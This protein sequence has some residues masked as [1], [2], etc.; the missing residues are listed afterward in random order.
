MTE[1]EAESLQRSPQSPRG[2][3][4]PAADWPGNRAVLPVDLEREGAA[5]GARQRGHG[6]RARAARRLRGS[7]GCGGERDPNAQPL[8]RPARPPPASSVSRAEETSAFPPWPRSS[9]GEGSAPPPAA[10]PGLARTGRSA[11]A[12]TPG[13]TALRMLRVA[14]R[15]DALPAADPGPT[16]TAVAER[17]ARALAG[18]AGGPSRRASGAASAG[19]RSS[20]PGLEGPPG[21]ST[22]FLGTF[23]FFF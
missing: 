20:Q 18:N 19:S 7:R 14:G 2:P 10:P 3:A 17:G 22:P 4:R 12:W 13:R 11:R 23:F 6:A 1:D 8:Q 16:G 15:R 5:L 21:G 9:R